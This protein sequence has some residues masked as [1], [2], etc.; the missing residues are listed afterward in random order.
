MRT[1]AIRAEITR[2]LRQVPFR[3]FVISMEN[4]QKV[5]IAHPENIAFESG[6]NG[7]AG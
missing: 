6:G 1:E 4:G 2:L 7:T 5:V 3:P